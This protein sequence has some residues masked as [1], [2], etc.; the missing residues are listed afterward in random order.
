M[1]RGNGAIKCRRKAVG[2]RLFNRGFTFYE[3]LTTGL[4]GNVPLVWYPCE[5]AGRA[6]TPL[7][8]DT[9]MKGPRQKRDPWTRS[10][11]GHLPSYVTSW[12]AHPLGSLASGLSNHA[13]K[14]NQISPVSSNKVQSGRKPRRACPTRHLSLASF[15]GILEILSPWCPFWLFGF[16][17]PGN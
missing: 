14:S 12:T 17:K 6:Q 16:H 7:Y 10:L 5:V 3:N 1:S 11:P 8:N 4:K 2:E 15:P 9:V 13:L